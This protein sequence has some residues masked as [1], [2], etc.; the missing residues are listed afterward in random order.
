MSRDA[1]DL[2]IAEYAAATTRA[3]MTANVSEVNTVILIRQL[4][5]AM[6]QR[7]AEVQ[8]ASPKP[9][10]CQPGCNACCHRVVPATVPEVIGA[11]K[12]VQKTFPQERLDA[13]HERLDSHVKEVES[14]H[15]VDLDKLRP[16]CPLLE[17]G[18]C[19]IYQMRPISCRGVKPTT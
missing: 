16:T 14:A 8:R 4:G 6:N 9:P 18:L 10:A 3:A 2:A 19:S 15:G 12:F 11:A 5:Q 13:L 17:N 1:I 7:I